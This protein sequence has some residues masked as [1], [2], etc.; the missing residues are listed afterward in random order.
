MFKLYYPNGDGTDRYI[1]QFVDMISC[2]SQI[3]IDN[4]VSY[5]I[6]QYSG[7]DIIMVM[8]C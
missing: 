8:S 5:T 2:L 3:V 4:Q 1:G 6:N 7:S